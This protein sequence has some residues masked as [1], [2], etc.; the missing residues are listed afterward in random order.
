M[1]ETYI[2]PVLNVQKNG[3]PKTVNGQKGS[4][5]RVDLN[6]IRN[7]GIMAHIDAGKTTTTERILYYTGRTY[8][9]GEV[10][11]GTAVMDWMDQERERGITITSAATTCPWRDHQINIIDT[12]GHVDFTAEV[13]R[14]LRVLDGAVAIFCAVGG[15]EP[16]SETVWRQADRYSVPRLAYI[17]KMDRSGADYYRVLRMIEERLGATAVPIQIPIGQSELFNGMVDLVKMTAITFREDSMGV[18]FD[19]GAIPADMTEIAHHWREKLLESVS[20]IDDTLMMKFLENETIQPEEI[21]AAL[22][23]ATIECKIVPVLCGSSFKHKGVQRLLDAIVE[24]LPS[25][26]DVKPT[27]GHHPQTEL[28]EERIADPNGP[29]AA[30]AFKIVTD[31][32]GR[33]TYFRVYSGKVTA[34]DAVLNATNGKRERLNRIIRMFANKRDDITEV[35]AGDI[36]AAIG[37]KDTR[38][39]DT[40]C[41]MKHPIVLEKMTFPEPVISITVEP[42]SQQEQEKLVDALIKLAEEDPTFRINYDQESGQTVIAGMGELHLEVLVERMK[43]EFGVK[44]HQGRPHVAYRESITRIAKGEGKY[45]RQTGGH[46]QYGHVKIVLEPGEPGS[47]YVFENKT[48]GGTIPREYVEPTNRG[49]KEALENGILAGFPLIDVKV[50]LMDGS[51]HEVDSSEIAFKIAGSMAIQDAVKHAGARIL[52]PV[53][54]LEVVTPDVYL[55]E[56]VGDL[57]SRRARIMGIDVR[58][59]AQVVSTEAP[60]ATMF[61]YATQLRSLTQG[62]AIFSME[63]LRYEPTPA[64]VQAEILE[65]VGGN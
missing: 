32:F 14:S 17:N 36:V 35:F 40:L 33:L 51:F 34:G 9:M 2:A 26:L 30:L 12:P 4:G 7:I 48:I 38:T 5:G 49:C 31:S 28:Q 57:N 58:N 64:N 55:G 62:R 50:S 42:Q 10:H 25:P 27:I 21:M 41:D 45:V 63:F 37:L 23:E 52:E 53:M 46:G 11:D 18:Q 61:G 1:S 16:Q 20:D 47:G 6:S 44:V 56:V 29:F 8:K 54:K 24:L 15:V 60:L 13:E 22:R 43:R 59:E 3:K 19:E 65:K 39:G